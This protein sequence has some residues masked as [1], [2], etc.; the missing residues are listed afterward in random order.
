MLIAMTPAQFLA[1]SS[2][3]SASATGTLL[4]AVRCES[5]SRVDLSTE[6]GASTHITSAEVSGSSPT[7]QC[8][9]RGTISLAIHFEVQLPVSSWNGRLVQTGCGGLCGT[10]AIRL[11]NAQSCLPAQRAE[12]ALAS[13][14]MGHMAKATDATRAQ[15]D[16]AAVIDFAYR[17]TH[18]MAVAAKS[19]KRAP[20]GERNP[21]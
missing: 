13:T 18:L 20:R 10:L 4:P 3:K 12:L 15:N 11:D 6:V 21:T 19:S 9:I 14:D 8:R 5:L 2:V 16:K 17:A 7:A 1:A